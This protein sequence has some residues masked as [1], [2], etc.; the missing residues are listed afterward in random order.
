MDLA[1]RATKSH[2]Y[3]LFAGAPGSVAAF[4][5]GMLLLAVSATAQN[6][7]EQQLGA[8]YALTTPT[9]DNTDIVTAGA[10][11]VLQKKGLTTGA[12]TSNVPMQNSYKDGQ[13]KTGAVGAISRFSHLGI[14]GIP[15]A[16]AAISNTPT[17]VFVNGEKVYVTKIEVKGNNVI[18]TLFSDAYDN[19]HYK[20]TL[21]FEF[22]KAV[23]A[24]NDVAK[25]Q[26]TLG[27][28]FTVDTSAAAAAP[29]QG[30][31]PAA[32]PDA[33]PAPIAP[34]AAPDPVL[35]PV[36]PPPPPVDQP[37]APPQTIEIGQTVD[38]V[39]AILGQPQKVA[40]LPGKEIYFYKNLKV[41]FKS[42]KVSDV[43]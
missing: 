3:R 7:L 34:P 2:G 16:P 12:A 24:S 32:A 1:R 26:Q 17:R 25:V 15:S 35:A 8:Q 10:V 4:S 38:Q 22:P 40:K 43:E 23:I 29:A 21:S 42:G 36:P 39:T 27:E 18:F 5:I 9:A 20:A 11:L 37:A 13:I 14:P 30:G 28:V 6:K 19:V 33:A 31:A 41:T